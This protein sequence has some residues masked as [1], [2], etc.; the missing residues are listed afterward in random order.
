MIQIFAL[1]LMLVVAY[2]Q[3]RNGLFGAC[4]MLIMVFLSGLVAFNFWEP[5][6]DTLDASFQNTVMAGCEDMISLAFLFGVTLFALRLAVNYLCPDMIAE[7]G[8]VQHF[9][10]AGVGLITGYFLAGFLI[11]AMQ[12]LPLDVHFM[13]FDPREAGESPL[14]SLYPSDRI[15]LSLMRHAGA[16]P[17]VWIKDN[18]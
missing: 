15:W 14:R 7:H 11:C 2:T 13:D 1:V 9:G 16:M 18:P 17:F 5:V 6:A 12:T 4:A 10:A 3:Y 8:A